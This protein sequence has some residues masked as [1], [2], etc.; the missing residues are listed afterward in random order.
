M[1]TDTATFAE[2]INDVR[3]YLTHKRIAMLTQENLEGAASAAEPLEGVRMKLGA[4]ASLLA[5]QEMPRVQQI[6]LGKIVLDIAG[7]LD[8]P[9]SACTDCKSLVNEARKHNW[10][11]GEPI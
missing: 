8:A 1:S 9:I 11:E 10:H 7:M 3:R 2:P 5:D 6:A 4:I